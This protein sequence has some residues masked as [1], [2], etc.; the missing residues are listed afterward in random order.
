MKNTYLARVIYVVT[1]F[2]TLLVASS[3]FAEY[4][5]TA[6]GRTTGYAELIANDALAAESKLV[7]VSTARMDFLEMNNLCVTKLLLEEFEAAISACAAALEKAEG[8]FGIGA[9]QGKKAK[10][11]IL[12]NMAVAR[13]IS[14]DTPNAKADLETALSLNST[15][16]NANI[17][18]AIVSEKI[19][20]AEV[21]AK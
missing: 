2:C 9:A 18:Y 4:R 11:S 16:R 8:D 1:G 6:F 12:S 17:N 5:V 19:V 3:A 7:K 13:A 10:A 20:T 15:D 21:A 14:G